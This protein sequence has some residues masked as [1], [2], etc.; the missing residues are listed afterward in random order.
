[1]TNENET[2][3][4]LNNLQVVPPPIIKRQDKPPSISKFK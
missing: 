4:D 1:M 3:N 2:F